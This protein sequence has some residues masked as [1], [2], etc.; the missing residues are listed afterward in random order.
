MRSGS[1]S[2]TDSSRLGSVRGFFAGGSLGFCSLGSGSLGFC[3]G[4]CFCSL[5]FCFC[6]GSCSRS[7]L[8]V[9][10]GFGAGRIG[11]S[12][13]SKSEST[14]H[15]RSEAASEAASAGSSSSVSAPLCDKAA[16]CEPS[17]DWAAGCA[18]EAWACEP[19]CDWAGGWESKSPDRRTGFCPF[20]ANAA[21]RPCSVRARVKVPEGMANSRERKQP[22]LV[23]AARTWPLNLCSHTRVGPFCRQMGL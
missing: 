7:R 2:S 5:G 14:T 6:S 3:S 1:L 19:S 16:G 13:S 12:S 11:S 8:M 23:H 21:S 17:C 10:V 22:P 18:G 4:F 9:T 20:N 15:S